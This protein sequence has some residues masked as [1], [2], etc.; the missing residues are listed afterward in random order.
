MVETVMVA[1]DGGVSSEAA[2]NWSFDRAAHF[3]VRL[4]VTTVI[5]PNGRAPHET[6][7]S[8]RSRR[9]SALVSSVGRIAPMLPHQ[10]IEKSV[11]YGNVA[12]ALI[13][14]SHGTDL[15]VVGNHPTSLLAGMVH[16]TLPLRLA[17]QTRCTTI[18]VP[19][20][21]QPSGRGVVVA[22]DDDNSADSALMFAASEADRRREPL[23]IVHSWKVP[24]AQI[25]DAD[26][27]T[28][29]FDEALRREHGILAEAAVTVRRAYPRV[30]VHEALE[31]GPAAVE[32]I[33]AA[34][35]AALLVVGTHSRRA[36]AS[37]LLGSVSHAALIN[38]PAP[39][40]IVPTSLEPSEVNSAEH[41]E[42][43][44]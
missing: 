36:G 33:A 21:W 1:I 15:L 10:V 2:L 39:V 32:V 3:P 23:T 37:F 14:A 8:Y 11:I 25:F 6:E 29:V 44:L 30:V 16:G 18:V 40:A 27:A 5:E 41:D 34:Q 20:D 7:A 38:M 24:S 22:W 19:S 42:V 17:G 9:E 4:D 35:G 28:L 43:L 12:T 26:G 31:A 13:Q